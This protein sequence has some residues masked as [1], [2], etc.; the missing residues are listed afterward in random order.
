MKTETIQ[1]PARE[2]KAGDVSAWGK[3]DESGIWDS[4][5]DEVYLVIDWA[6]VILKG[7]RIITIS[8][9]LSDPCPRGR[10]EL[11]ASGAAWI[12]GR[13]IGH[14]SMAEQAAFWRRV[15]RLFNEAEDATPFSTT[16]EIEASFV[17]PMPRK[18][19]ES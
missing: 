2:V 10:M 5:D 6:D 13:K 12:G 3:V 4:E 14:Y 9:P 15:V 11:D 1:I 18:E 19:G 17:P 7:G 16:E 8:R